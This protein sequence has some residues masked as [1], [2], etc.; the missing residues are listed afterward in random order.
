MV[1]LY[2]SDCGPVSVVNFGN[3]ARSETINT[4][5]SN[6]EF[7]SSLFG[8]PIYFRRLRIAFFRHAKDG[9]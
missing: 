6:G 7:G 5:A 2:C 3:L 8:D 4:C 9:N 1:L